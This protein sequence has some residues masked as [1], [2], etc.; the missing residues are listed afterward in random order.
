MPIVFL[1]ARGSEVDRVLGFKLG[2][3]DYVTKP[4]SVNELVARV[5]AIL[6]RKAPAPAPKPRSLGGIA[7]DHDSRE[8]R[9]KGKAAKLTPKEFTLLELLMEAD[10]KVVSRQTL[11]KSIWGYDRKLGMDDRRVDHLV[12]CLRRSLKSEG[13]R[14]LTVSGSGYRVKTA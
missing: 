14:I 6:K 5:R 9:V 7:V 8:V 13:A 10:G 12:C 2:G 11:M 3:D 1:T 4:F